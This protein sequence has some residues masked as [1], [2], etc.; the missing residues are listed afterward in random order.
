[1]EDWAEQFRRETA[2]FS[3]HEIRVVEWSLVARRSNV[4]QG[5]DIGHA[6]QKN[7]RHHGA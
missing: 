6:Q 7:S 1:M 4:G 3:R 5:L 2:R